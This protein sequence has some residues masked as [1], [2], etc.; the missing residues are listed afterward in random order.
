MLSAM[1]HLLFT[2][3]F[4]C[5]I[6][7][8]LKAQLPFHVEEGGGTLRL[9]LISG[10]ESRWLDACRVKRIS[11]TRCS[12]D[13]PLLGGGTLRLR[14]H[15]LPTT[16]GFVV[17]VE[18]DHLPDGLQL[19]WA[20]GACNP[21]HVQRDGAALLPEACRDNVF[22]DEGHL[23]S[24]YYGE[25]MALR[26]VQ[27]VTPPESRMILCDAHRQE[28]PLAF[29]H[30]GKRTDAPAIASLL[31]LSTKGHYYFCF[32]RPNRTADYTYSMLPTLLPDK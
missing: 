9:G 25:V 26:L 10:K 24:V 22:S 23:V 17:E 20:F 11:A 29:Y 5:S 8:P 21:H 14:V 15:P 19:L 27:G 1:T 13:D 3:M 16:R 28:T 12:I 18:T 31:S 2:L 4:L 30:S 32:Y 7:Y 6:C